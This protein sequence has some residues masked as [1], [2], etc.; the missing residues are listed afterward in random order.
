MY[1]PGA[2]EE[3]R[4]DV[5]HDFIEKFPFATIVT[6]QGGGSLIAS[7]LPLLLE[8][9]EGRFGMLRGHIAKANPQFLH[10]RQASQVLVIFQGPNSY[11]SP[12][13]Y[14]N[15]Q[16]VPTWNY[17]V[18]H[19]YGTPVLV[20]ESDLLAILSRTA[21][22]NE[23]TM[24]P[25]WPY[26]LSQ[27]WIKEMLPEIAGFHI[28]ISDLQGKFKLNQNRTAADREGVIRALAGSED[29][30]KRA[31]ADLMQARKEEPR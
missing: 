2:F 31:I 29:S 10:F 15:Q 4:T 25:K 11:V 12:T 30:A 21:D 18:V 9:G 1:I 6:G 3:R 14:Q 27:A 28:P 13:W 24:N 16:N 7:H 22:V 17:A 5:L 23:A 8:R 26:D 20:G 19:A